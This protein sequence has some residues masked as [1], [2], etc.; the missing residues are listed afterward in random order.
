MR[1]SAVAMA[2]LV[3]AFLAGPV[4]AEETQ[5][6]GWAYELAGYLMSPYC[7]GRTLSDCPSPQAQDLR[8]WIIVQEAAG[9][10]RAEVEE[11]LYA[12]FGD[13]IR[14]APKAEGFGLAAYAIPV[15]GFLA[16]GLLV[17]LFLRRQ[18]LRGDEPAAAPPAP[19]GALDPE[20]ER[21]V[22]EDLAR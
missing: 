4:A 13:V 2:L 1:R 22:D 7:P 21:L 9:R 17:A 14:P 15:V 3:A 18:T 8:M 6:E 20:L 11:D 16:G 5:P 12:R 19:A 10:S